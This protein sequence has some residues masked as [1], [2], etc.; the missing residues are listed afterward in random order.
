MNGFLGIA[1]IIL[2]LYAYNSFMNFAFINAV[3]E[4]VNPP[5]GHSSN[6]PNPPAPIQTTL[7]DFGAESP[8]HMQWA[9]ERAFAYL[10]DT[11]NCIASFMSDMGKHEETEHLQPM[12]AMYAMMCAEDTP[13]QVRAFLD[14]FNNKMGA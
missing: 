13:E 11:Q 14:G 8:T 2:A 5:S 7:A 10:P 1:L 9:K 4:S 12:V 3:G 6:E